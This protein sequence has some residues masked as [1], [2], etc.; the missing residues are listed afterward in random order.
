[1]GERPPPDPPSLGCY[2]HRLE[3]AQNVAGGSPP[4][5][6]ASCWACLVLRSLPMSPSCGPPPHPA[7][8]DICSGCFSAWGMRL[9]KGKRPWERRSF[10]HL[11]RPP[12]LSAMI[13][14]WAALAFG[15]RGGDAEVGA[16]CWVAVMLARGIWPPR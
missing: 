2:D 7:L 8:P 6:L 13:N 9:L 1:M 5:L 3:K 16:G 15:G 11:R 10:S 14:A 4:P 12:L